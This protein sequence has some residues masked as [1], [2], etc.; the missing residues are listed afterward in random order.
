MSKNINS[1]NLLIC[2]HGCYMAF[3]NTASVYVRM[4][5]KLTKNNPN[6]P[7]IHEVTTIKNVASSHLECIDTV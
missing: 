1:V 2:K 3:R 6:F 7:T 4:G 5:L